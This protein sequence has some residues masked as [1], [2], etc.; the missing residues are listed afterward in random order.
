M[1]AGFDL[2]VVGA[3]P[4]GMAA[5]VAAEHGLR[6]CLA[7]A[8]PETGGQIWRGLSAGEGCH[9]GQFAAWR[10][11]LKAAGVTLLK[12]WQAVE[13]PRPG[14][15]RLQSATSWRDAAYKKLVI[16]TGARERF[17]PFPGWTLPGVMGA[18]AL[19][20]LLK[21][22]LDLQGKRVVVAGSGPLLLAAAAGAAGAGANV[23]G[24]FEQAPLGRMPGLGL[25]TAL[26]HPAKIAEGLG[27]RLRTAGAV[28]RFSSWVVRAEGE[29]R[30]ERVVVRV[31][32]LVELRRR[33]WAVSACSTASGVWQGV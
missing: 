17:L 18:G 14:V 1:S 16:A 22:G 19:Q 23:E 10:G 28:Y 11:R 33:L 8:E 31:G 15:L 24:I 30:L 32:V 21:S 7:D 6:V 3:G 4:A 5:A 20:A 2:M 13:A 9:G 25:R 27:Y 26:R 29:G 12:G